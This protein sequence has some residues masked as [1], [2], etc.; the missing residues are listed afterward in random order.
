M[1]TGSLIVAG[2]LALLI[3]GAIVSIIMEKRSGKCSCGCDCGCC[4]RD[5][6]G[7]DEPMVPKD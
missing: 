7:P 2:V 5:C 3:I 6:C 1:T 4:G